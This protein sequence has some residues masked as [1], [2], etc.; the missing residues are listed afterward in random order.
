MV[1]LEKYIQITESEE[2]NKKGNIIDWVRFYFGSKKNLQNQLKQYYNLFVQLSKIEA[3]KQKAVLKRVNPKNI[4][5]LNNEIED[6]KKSLLS[7][8]QEMLYYIEERKLPSSY[9]S[10]LKEIKD[11]E[12][13]KSRIAYRK[14]KLSFS[15][16]QRSKQE[17][18]NSERLIKKQQE[19]VAK[20]D[21][22]VEAFEKDIIQKAK[23][24]K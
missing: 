11:K 5:T 13:K 24:E 19:E 15:K 1:T 17:I 21:K 23:K 7:M 20:K 16:A 18:E 4:E 3:K 22:K 12:I 9:K 10:K 8:E 2:D 14:L 6:I